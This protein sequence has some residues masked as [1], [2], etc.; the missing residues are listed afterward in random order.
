MVMNSSKGRGALRERIATLG[1]TYASLQVLA[2]LPAE[3]TESP[4]N[5]PEISSQLHGR[6]AELVDY[7][8]E[9]KEF[10]ANKGWHSDAEL[11]DFCNLRCV[12]TL[13]HLNSFNIL[14]VF[15]HD[16]DDDE[17]R[18]WFRPFIKS[19]LIWEEDLYRSKIGMPSLL[20]EDLDGL[21]HSVF[22][23]LVDSEA[24]NP[25]L[26]WSRQFPKLQQPR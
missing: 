7:C 12:V 3:A 22:F 14:R 24:A 23:N 13:P 26:E 2:L 20:A 25:Y 11:I 5:C 9:L 18:D 16:I 10:V 1:A 17:Q 4:F 6:I 15:Y 8:P 21:S 19:M